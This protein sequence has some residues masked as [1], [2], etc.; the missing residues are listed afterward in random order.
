M[1]ATGACG[2]KVGVRVA[3][4]VRTVTAGDVGTG[5][6]VAVGVRVGVGLGSEVGVLA[7]VS[8]GARAGTGVSTGVGKGVSRAWM[9]RAMI[10]GSCS[11]DKLVGCAGRSTPA[12]QLA[13]STADKISSASPQTL[14][15]G[16]FL[17]DAVI[18][19]GL[20]SGYFLPRADQTSSLVSTLRITSSVKSVVVIGPARSVV[21]L[22]S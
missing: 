12:M 6:S 8:V 20:E 14:E 22:P 5:V 2:V 17:E 3:V 18:Q 15:A 10:V 11:R 4:D 13:S 21:P 19:P 9:V 7:G 16:N 1:P